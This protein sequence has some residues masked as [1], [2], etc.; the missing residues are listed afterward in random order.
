[1][2]SVSAGE[3]DEDVFEACATF[4]EIEH[5]PVLVSREVEDLRERIFFCVGFELE[6]DAVFSA[7]G[8]D[9]SDPSE[10]REGGF[11]LGFLVALFLVVLAFLFLFFLS[12]LRTGAG[13]CSSATAGVVESLAWNS[14]VI[15]SA[16]FVLPFMYFHS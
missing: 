7:G 10:G 11:D 12:A 14:R 5:V 13:M 9:I 3:V 8:R 1:M 16:T 6:G 4:C 2:D 15:G